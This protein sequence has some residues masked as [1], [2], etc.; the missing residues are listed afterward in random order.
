MVKVNVNDSELKLRLTG[1]GRL[2]H[3]SLLCGVYW[4][5]LPTENWRA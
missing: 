1:L 4:V 3:E 2:L 5:M